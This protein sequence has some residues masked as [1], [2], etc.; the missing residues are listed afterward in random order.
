MSD[1]FAYERQ[2]GTGAVAKAQLSTFTIDGNKP[3]LIQQWDATYTQ[4][5]AEIYEVGTKN[6]YWDVQPAKGQGRINRLVGGDT[7]TV[8]SKQIGNLFDA[9]SGVAGTIQTKGITCSGKGR[10]EEN[11]ATITLKGMVATSVGFNSQVQGNRVQEDV[12]IKFTSM[13]IT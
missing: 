2:T 4:E 1:V 9:C 8:L 6:V 7:L 13:E 3:S 12:G 5:V 10:I 11:L